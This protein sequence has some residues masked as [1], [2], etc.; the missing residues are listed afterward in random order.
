[1]AHRCRDHRQIAFDCW[2]CGLLEDEN[3]GMKM[4]DADLHSKLVAGTG[5]DTTSPVSRKG[6]GI[7]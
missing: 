3:Y 2:E 7:V 6:E 1:M 4:F 5:C